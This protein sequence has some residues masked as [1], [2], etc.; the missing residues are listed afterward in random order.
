[1]AKTISILGVDGKAKGRM[2]LP[3]E[4]FGVKPNKQL[5]AQAVRVY[6]ANQR[7]GTASTKTRGEVEG[8]TRKI[9]RQKGTGRARHGAIRAPIFVG[10]GITFGPKPRSF[11]LSMPKKMKRAALV[12]ALSS[13]ASTGEVFVI[14]GLEDLTSKTKNFARV[15]DAMKITGRTLMVVEKNAQSIIHGARNL[16]GVEITIA[17]NLTAYDVL[18]HKNIVFTKLALSHLW[19]K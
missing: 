15:F 3:A 17:P 18:A 10:G 11:R 12:S 16:E 13:K 1:M 7:T 9:Y 19:N 2:T 14:D 6:L 8:S 4:L 5:V